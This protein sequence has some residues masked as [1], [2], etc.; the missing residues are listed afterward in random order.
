MEF[1]LESAGQ[2]FYSAESVESL[3]SVWKLNYFDKKNGGYV[4]TDKIRDEVIFRVFN[5]MDD[6]FPFKKKFHVILVKCLSYGCSFSKMESVN[7]CPVCRCRLS[8]WMQANRLSSFPKIAPYQ[9][10]FHSLSEV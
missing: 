5:L 3:P 2:G 9:E 10:A 4:I 7:T 8:G 6:R 1:F